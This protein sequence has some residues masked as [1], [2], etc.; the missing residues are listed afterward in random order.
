MYL[1]PVLGR[2]NTSFINDNNGSKPLH[3]YLP[4]IPLVNDGMSQFRQTHI[5]QSIM[6]VILRSPRSTP[7]KYDRSIPDFEENSSWVKPSSCRLSLMRLPKS[8]SSFFSMKQ[9]C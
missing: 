1:L 7:P 6:I 3:S 8:I 2:D 5:L 4:G 9:K